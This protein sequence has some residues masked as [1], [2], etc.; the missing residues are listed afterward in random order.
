MSF[1]VV[2]MA[3]KSA[4]QACLNAM[5]TGDPKSTAPRPERLLAHGRDRVTHHLRSPRERDHHS[6]LKFHPIRARGI[7]LLQRGR[8]RKFN[9]VDLSVR[10]LDRLLAQ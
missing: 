3:S 1:H 4:L 2:W 10:S 5:I 7:R 9:I 8:D 6:P